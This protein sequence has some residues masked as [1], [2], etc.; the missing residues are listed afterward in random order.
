MAPK[1]RQTIDLNTLD[2][3]E[4]A[5]LKQDLEGQ[6]ESLARSAMVLQQTAGEF[7]K[8]GQAIEILSEQKDGELFFA[9]S[10]TISC[11]TRTRSM[12]QYTCGNT[13]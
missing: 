2:L 11:T 5:G 13:V 10:A 6:V 8:A 9:Q 3:R 1:E 4:L 7:G 12:A